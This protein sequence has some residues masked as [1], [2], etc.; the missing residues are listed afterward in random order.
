VVRHCVKEQKDYFRQVGR[1]DAD[2][3]FPDWQR[4]DYFLVEEFQELVKEELELATTELLAL[5]PRQQELPLR[6]SPLT[7]HQALARQVLQ[8]RQLLL[9]AP[10][11][12]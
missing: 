12:S 1:P 3:P 9:P 8:L 2:F 6:P 5:L 7:L 11:Q 10:R 4:M